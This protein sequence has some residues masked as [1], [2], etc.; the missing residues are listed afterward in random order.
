MDIDAFIKKAKEKEKADR[1]LKAEPFYVK[2]VAWFAY[3]GLLRHNKIEPQRHVVTLDEV[4]KAGELEPRIFEVLPAVMIVLSDALKLDQKEI[5]HDL[6]AILK[7]IRTRKAVK[8]FRGVP[9][10]K[11]LHWMRAHVMDVA[12]RRLNFQ[13]APRRRMSDTHAIGETIRA[14]R[15]NLALTQR[16]LAEKYHLSLRVIRDLE[17]GKLDASLKAT[18]E[19]LAVFGLSLHV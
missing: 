14:G 19:I 4:L 17:Q 8:D 1:A 16:Q 3:L 7:G 10:D 5:P 2:T 15:L 18:N 9:P 12:K 6:A 11:Y 13:T